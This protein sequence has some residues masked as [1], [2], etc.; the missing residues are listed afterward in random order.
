MSPAMTSDRELDVLL[1]E[2]PVGRLSLD[3]A[4]TSVF[5][6]FRT[7]RDRYP[8]PVLG[9]Q[10]E[11][12]L[13]GRHQG[14]A[15]R[16]PVW[17]S[18]LLP[19]GPLRTRAESELGRRKHEI[20]LLG[21]L[22]DDLP[23]A[24]RFFPASF[25]DDVETGDEYEARDVASKNNDEG[26]MRF[27]LAGVQDKFPVKRDPDGGFTLPP[28]GVGGD[29]ILKLPDR[30]YPLVPINEHAMMTWARLAGL[31]VP[32]VTLVGPEQV[33]GIDQARFLRGERAFVVE[34]F[35]RTPAGDRI[36]IEDFAQVWGQ[37]PGAKYDDRSFEDIARVTRAV[38][39]EI[40]YQEL[41]KRLVFMVVSGNHDMHLKNWSLRY[42]D[43]MTASLAPA[44]D[45]VA[46]VA[47]PDVMNELALKLAGSKRWER[48]MVA[49]FERL[50]KETGA[51]VAHTRQIVH[52]TVE[53]LSKSLAEARETTFLDSEAWERIAAH[54][55]RVPLFAR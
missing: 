22:A 39:G 44:Y 21:A 49:S 54:Q 25:D 19:E 46:T 1:G 52:E 7:Y 43:G 6:F 15:G 32:E 42:R 29:W 34:R 45:L 40:G 8:R 13:S 20:Y 11:D 37:Y 51:N 55:K 3:A 23:G 2:I 27:S 9:Q 16:L 41:L 35:D 38:A 4:G 31:D 50:A 17:F 24:V 5:S 36:H 53:A 26:R 28:G 30:T 12:D 18:N 10:F 47:Y 14:K 48:V 33:R